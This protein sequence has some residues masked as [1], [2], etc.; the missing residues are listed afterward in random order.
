[1]GRYMY[2]LFGACTLDAGMY[3]TLESDASMTAEAALTVLLASAAAGAGWSA[4]HGFDWPSFVSAAALSLTLWIAWA[5]LIHQIGARVLPAPATSATVGE[6]LRT[7]G[8]AAAPGMSLVFGVFDGARLAVFSAAGLWM[9]AAMIVA[10][11][12]ALDY[13]T[14]LRAVAVAAVALLICVVF[15]VFLSASFPATAS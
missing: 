9:F 15:A 6:L 11:R 3:E 4:M 14:N 10:I 1:M 13:D 7:T 5:V 8:F 12:H 2:R